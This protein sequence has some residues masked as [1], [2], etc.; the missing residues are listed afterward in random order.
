[1]SV[2]RR[3]AETSLRVFVEFTSARFGVRARRTPF[4]RG[5]SVGRSLRPSR[6]EGQRSGL[7]SPYE[8]RRERK[9]RV[10]RRLGH[11]RPCSLRWAF[12]WR[13]ITTGGGTFGPTDVVESCS[14]EDRGCDDRGR[15]T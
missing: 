2:D 9:G 6:L 5:V 10:D 1:M 13:E 15:G 4:R 12:D 3:D 14:P 8:L 7:E 11:P